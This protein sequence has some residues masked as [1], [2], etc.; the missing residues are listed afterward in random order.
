M[1]RNESAPKALCS[2]PSSPSSSSEWSSSSSSIVAALAILLVCLR[3][4]YGLCS[5]GGVLHHHRF[6]SRLI[7]TLLANTTLPSD[8]CDFVLHR[9]QSICERSSSFWGRE[10]LLCFL[11]FASFFWVFFSFWAFLCMGSPKTPT[12]CLSLS[13]KKHQK[14][15]TSK[16]NTHPHPPPWAFFFSAPWLLAF[17]CF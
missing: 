16:K 2:A 8:A 14:P 4:E 7:F 13:L 12:R 1:P 9:L 10:A 15:K 5:L 6:C 3:F 11:L 17:F